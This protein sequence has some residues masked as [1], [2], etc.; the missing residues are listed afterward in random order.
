MAVD[1]FLYCTN[2]QSTED[3]V[4]CFLQAFYHAIHQTCQKPVKNL[5]ETYAGWPQ[6]GTPDCNTTGTGRDSVLVPW[7]EYWT[8]ICKSQI[9]RV[10]RYLAE[11]VSK[12]IFQL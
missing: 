12:N 8:N 7:V 4:F 5:Y 9:L 10:Y 6:F 1:Q 3:N 11:Y 2:A